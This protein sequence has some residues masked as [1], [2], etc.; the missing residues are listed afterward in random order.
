MHRLLPKARAQRCGIPKPS[1]MT[2]MHHPAPARAQLY[3]ALSAKRAAQKRSQ[4]SLVGRVHDA[5][6]KVQ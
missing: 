5:E 1:R 4:K 3:A 2:E 6:T